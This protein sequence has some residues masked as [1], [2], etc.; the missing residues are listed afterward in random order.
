MQRCRL[1]QRRPSRS[2]E[3]DKDKQNMTGKLRTSAYGLC[4]LTVGGPQEEDQRQVAEAELRA[5]VCVRGRGFYPSQ[6]R[7]A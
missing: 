1:S 2:S 4:V 5:S 6:A 3:A 7:P